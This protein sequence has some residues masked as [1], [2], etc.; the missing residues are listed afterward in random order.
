MAEGIRL[1]I[2]VDD[3][4]SPV[5]KTVTDNLDKLAKQSAASAAAHDNG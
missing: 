3:K 5:I 1:E 2:T 4:G